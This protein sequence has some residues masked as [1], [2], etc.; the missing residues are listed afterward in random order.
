MFGG[1][2]KKLVFLVSI[3]LI[4]ATLTVT[5]C[6]TTSQS[7]AQTYT[8]T[9][10][11]ITSSVT[12]SGVLSYDPEISVVSN[13][14]GKVLQVYVEEGA[15]VRKEDVVAE[16][17]S[18]SAKNNYE[19]A[20][21][22]YQIS[23]MNYLI[24]EASLKDLDTSLEQAKAN[25]ETAQLSY[26][27]T[28]LNL[29]IS[30]VSDSS[31]VQLIQAQQQYKN[32]E[33]NLA[34][35]E[36]T[37]EALKDPSDD[38]I[39]SAE[40]QI[41]NAQTSL[42]L[43]QQNLRVL[44]ESDT[45]E[46]GVISAEEQLR[47]AKLNLENAQKKLDEAAKN[48]NTSDSEIESLQNQIISAQINVRT[49]ERNLEKAKNPLPSTEDEIK[50]TEYQVEAAEI[51]LKSAIQNYND[52]LKS[53]E[54]S[55]ELAKMNFEIAKANLDIITK[56]GS[57]TAEESQKSKELQIK[58]AEI[59]LNNAKINVDSVN[60]QIETSKLKLEEQKLQN[61]QSYKELQTLKS[62]LDDYII[63]SPIDGVV[64]SV[65]IK[66]G[67]PVQTNSTVAKVGNTAKFVI[68]AYA[69]EVDVVNIEVGQSVSISFDQFP[70]SKLTGAIKSVGMEKVSTSQGASVYEVIVQVSNSNLNLK[71]GFSVNLDVV[72]ASKENVIAAPISS[73]TTLANG[74][75][76]VDLVGTDGKIQRVE[77]M[78][79][80]TGSTFTEIVSGLKEGDKI[81]LIPESSTSTS[82]GSSNLRIPGMGGPGGF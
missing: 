21:I 2:M 23:Q 33:I 5:G 18:T 42:V 72:T 11:N 4:F 57:L 76:F 68:T 31:E 9:K 65:G 56:S 6:K 19:N 55:L 10:R 62:S 39:S 7:T 17:D 45:Q 51:N 35:A 38:N 3:M 50:Q 61:D 53:A 48:S 64:V 15:K 73:I 75:S 30:E 12:L 69:D 1:K 13:V 40:I 20:L 36:S 71:S 66:E 16:I 54:N 41:K 24:S 8:V 52:Q 25:L 32:A 63:K 14:S 60:R 58:Q 34:N 22:N 49:A 29:A 70:G 43:A 27:I 79:G 59:A 82:G 77:V 80:I 46:E 28:E 47:L 74:K 44:K 67:D 81:L 37:L 78:T 26:E